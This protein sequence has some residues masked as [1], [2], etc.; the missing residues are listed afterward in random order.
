L[1]EG[2]EVPS[3]RRG[4]YTGQEREILLCVVTRG[5]VS[6][7]KGLV[8]KV[9]PQTILIISPASEV[10][11]RGLKPLETLALRA[12]SQKS[13]KKLSIWMEREKIPNIVIQ[14]ASN[15]PE[16]YFTAPESI[17]TFGTYRL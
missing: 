14:Y 15:S 13:E 6:L 12:H 17:C 4:I 1:E 8:Y 5:E 10:V 16:T 7:L 9:D 2:P 11:G 3:P